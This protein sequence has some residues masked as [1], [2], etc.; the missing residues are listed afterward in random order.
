MSRLAERT[1]GTVRLG[2]L[3]TVLLAGLFP[4]AVHAQYFGRNKVRYQGF[5]FRVLET[6]HF[7]VYYY[8]REREAA[9][10]AARMAERWYA[11]FSGLTGDSLTGKQPLILYASHPEFAQT[12]A[13]GGEIGE[14]TGGVTEG[15][16][17]RIVLPL[18]GSRPETDHVIGHEL[19]HA[20]QYNL[21]GIAPTHPTFGTP[22]I[23]GM[24]L[25][26]V[27]GL[28]EYLSIGPESPLTA[29]WMRDAVGDEKGRLPKVRD[30]EDAYRYF[31][32]RWGHA[33]WA[34]IGGTWGD[35][36]VWR[37]FKTSLRVGPYAAIDSVLGMSSDTLSARWH[38]ALRDAYQPLRAGT[39][40]AEEV[41]TAL[42]TDQR[43]GSDMNVGPALSP[44]GRRL[45]FLS[46]KDP[47][48]IDL[49][50]ADAE[51]GE[52]TR[53]VTQSALDPHYE[54]LH[55]VSSAG[56]WAP[57]GERV[58][59]TTVG[60]GKP[61]IVILN[62]AS[63]E[64][65]RELRLRRFGSVVNPTWS[66]D[67]KQIAFAA[68]E[69]GYFDLWIITVE[70]GE[71]RRLTEDAFAEIHP[72]WSPDGQ[73]I[74]FTTDRAGGHRYGLATIEVATG[75]V[76]ELPGFRGANNI[77]PR[78]APDGAALY[79]VS[80]DGGIPNLYR[81]RLGAGTPERVTRLFGGV[82]GITELSPVFDV[83]S[84][85]GRIVFTS[86]EIGNWNLYRLDQPAALAAR[87]EGEQRDASLLPPRTRRDTGIQAFFRDPDAG[88]PD[89]GSFTQRSYRAGLS[90][91]YVAPPTL[92][93]A[94]G[95]F[96]SFIGAGGALYWSDMLGYHSLATQFQLQIQNGNVLNGIGAQVTYVNQR[97][98][99][100]W[101]LLGGQIPQLYQAFGQGL[102]DADGDGD[103]EL[104][105][106][107]TQYWIISRRALGLFE[108][109]FSRSHRL[110]LSGGFERMD[111]EAQTERRIFD[112]PSFQELDKVKI[113]AP[114]CGDSLSIR[115]DFCEPGALTQFQGAAALVYD[116]TLQG[117]TGPIAGQ[118]YRL[119]VSPS[120]GTL[121]YVGVLGDYRAYGRL[122]GPVTL[123]GRLLH[124]GRY[125]K[126]AEDQRLSQL[127]LGYPSLIRGYDYGS[128]DLS[129][130]P[131]DQPIEDC[132][133]IDVYQQLF[134]SR[135]ALAN[136]ELRISLF[137]PVG[138]LSRGFPLPA[139][140]VGFY[141]AGVAWS[142]DVPT[143]TEDERASFLGGDRKLLSS[144]G[145]GLRFNLFGFALAELHWVYPFER[146]VRKGYLTFVFNTGF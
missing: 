141:D 119:E 136:A 73:R 59:L 128:F 104:L 74:A 86:F 52:V 75:Q 4:A 3:I 38:Q 76:T 35:A 113:E 132:S 122:A 45:L 65:L 60:D 145:V 51:T 98:R 50:L 123:A 142:S 12:T 22:T 10:D 17:R 36:A 18:A 24:P 80:D 14:A 139:D 53:R 97:H 1:V 2:W 5:D 16:K 27:E 26:L 106:E 77:N 19:V 21:A 127:F 109:P 11:R 42:I 48:S 126:D 117:F 107:L 13:I 15:L 72:A 143:T 105:Q 124:Y 99:A 37:L 57:D 23:A 79:F 61:M 83:A 30:L 129:R 56:A 58:A 43:G 138:I 63:G 131:I 120:L 137:G 100:S 108:Y 110:E 6:E 102:V 116:N 146:P 78:W 66:P 69:G 40:R 7:E 101:G 133:E 70:N 134:G 103:A 28:A 135:L 88:L 81:L 93:F 111:F 8:E 67:G 121:D 130:C 47:Y 90:L 41:A 87:A 55:F 85:S 32:Y 54:Y 31:P 9:L 84:Q 46:S 25:W 144:A 64:R 39:N 114:A 44:D 29:M 71:L 33:L 95:S 91:D 20:F 96:G 140:L 125:A 82:S 94:V 92:G 89:P 49:Y 62:P 34:Y 112:L 68:N 118:R 115:F